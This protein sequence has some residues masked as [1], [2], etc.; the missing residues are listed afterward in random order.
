MTVN[1]LNFK[2]F[3]NLLKRFEP[4]D[5]NEPV[6]VGVSGGS[7]SLAL[8]FLLKRWTDTKGMRLYAVTLDHGLRPESRTEALKVG[9]WLKDREI[10]H[11]ILCWEGQKPARGVQAKARMAR[12]TLIQEWC[13]AQNI[14]TLF[15]AHHLDDQLETSLM[16]LEKE[17]GLEGLAGMS[18]IKEWGSLRMIRPFLNLSKEKLRH[19]L[20]SEGHPWI[21][22]PSND[23]PKFQRS[24]IRHALAHSPLKADY[25]T[26]V[27]S[28]GYFRCLFERLVNNFLKSFVES[29]PE[30]YC[31]I[32]YPRFSVLSEELQKVI[33][34]RLLLT[35]GTL[36]YPLKSQKLRQL[37]KTLLN[38]TF[39]AVT[40]GG[41][42]LFLRKS[43]LYVAREPALCREEK[44]LSFV[45]EAEEVLWDGRFSLKIKT[46]S[47]LPPLTLKAL[48][49]EGWRQVKEK[50]QTQNVLLFPVVLGLP[51]FWLRERVVIVPHLGYNTAE[52]A[53]H[54]DFNVEVNFTPRY[55]LVRSIF[56]LT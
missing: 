56:T 9:D 42:Y 46:K 39:K 50:K 40:A 1:P 11:E 49:E 45:Q 2:E 19:F 30:G 4:F 12:Y 38:P 22:D 6:A 28:F 41:C 37:R 47:P 43:D 32:S 24:K 25:T 35:V 13:S 23:N 51:A 53:F 20:I 36:P 18:A 26:L 52:N 8:A 34:S 44:A 54:K 21:E 15:L 55:P 5:K 27:K 14:R 7:D 29:F 33:L 3:E 10:A 31:K 17:S 48:G 16:R